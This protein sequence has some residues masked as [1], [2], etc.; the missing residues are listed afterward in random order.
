M[1]GGINALN[2]L[3]TIASNVGRKAG[4]AARRRQ[5]ERSFLLTVRT[6]GSSQTQVLAGGLTIDCANSLMTDLVEA[7]A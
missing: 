1:A 2:T 6:K 5:A 7:L 3:N 4:N